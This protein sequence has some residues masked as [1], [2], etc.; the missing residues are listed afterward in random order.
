MEKNCRPYWCYILIAAIFLVAGYFLGKYC[1]ACGT[2][3]ADH[4]MD[5]GAI[6]G[7]EEKPVDALFEDL[8]LVMLPQDEYE[9]LISAIEQTALGLL[10]A[11]AKDSN[12]Q[13]TPAMEEALKN[14]VKQKYSRQFFTSI[15]SDIVKQLNKD[16][17]VKILYFYSSTAGKKIRELTPE[18]ISKTMGAVQSDITVWLPEAVN[19]TLTGEKPTGNAQPD[20]VVPEPKAEK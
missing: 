19:I 14:R 6:K 20:I 3:V 12:A 5:E 16:E 11:K 7:F 4:G 2:K 17:L 15:S 10:N 9:K 8:S 18:V 13:I 1:S